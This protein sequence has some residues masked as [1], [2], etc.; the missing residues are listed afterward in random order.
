MNSSAPTFNGPKNF[1]QQAPTMTKNLGVKNF[2]ANKN[3][4]GSGYANIGIFVIS[5]IAWIIA[6]LRAKI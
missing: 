3:V 4:S 2:K 1:R 6:S 5:L